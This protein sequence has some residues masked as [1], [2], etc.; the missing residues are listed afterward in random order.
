MLQ[1]CCWRCSKSFVKDIEK[2]FAKRFLRTFV[3]QHFWLMFFLVYTCQH[4]EDSSMFLWVWLISWSIETCSSFI[5]TARTGDV[6]ESSSP[7]QLR[8]KSGPSVFSMRQRLQPRSRMC[9]HSLTSPGLV[10]HHSRS[11]AAVCRVEICQ[12]SPGSGVSWPDSDLISRVPGASPWPTRSTSCVPPTPR[13]SWSPPAS[14]TPSW[15]RWRSSGQP[16]ECQPSCGATQL[17]ARCWRAAL[18]PRL[19]GWAGG[20]PRTRSWCE[21]WLRPVLMT[22]APPDTAVGQTCPAVTRLAMVEAF[23]LSRICQPRQQRGA[24]WERCWLLTPGATLQ[25]WV[26][27]LGEG[28][29]S[30]RSIILMQRFSSWTWQTSTASGRASWLSALSATLLL[31]RPPGSRLWTA[32]S[33]CITCLG[34]WKLQSDVSQRCRQVFTIENL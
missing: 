33:G 20:A 31:T 3:L 34:C 22:V 18:S 2:N 25:L 13:R 27:E 29:W 23:P 6:T 12:T 15:R 7:P 19:A 9:S 30:V 28:E 5:S 24:R 14:P 10:K 26:T 16:G 1:Y 32:P 17:M 4:R 21:Q 11:W 8:V